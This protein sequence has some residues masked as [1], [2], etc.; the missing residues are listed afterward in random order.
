MVV[1]EAIAARSSLITAA[2]ALPGVIGS[3]LSIGE[4]RRWRAHGHAGQSASLTRDLPA[5]RLIETLVGEINESLA[6]LVGP[7]GHLA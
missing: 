4:G 1:L 3:Y 2:I 5:A 6:R 7:T